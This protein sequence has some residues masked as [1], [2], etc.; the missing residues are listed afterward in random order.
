M[1]HKLRLPSLCINNNLSWKR[2]L[3]LSTYA[4]DYQLFTKRQ[5]TF[6]I[7]STQL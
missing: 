5:C 1:L 4:T 7:T 2:F 3:Q 6:F